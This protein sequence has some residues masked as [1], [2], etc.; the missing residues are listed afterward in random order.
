MRRLLSGRL[1][2]SGGSVGQWQILGQSLRLDVGQRTKLQMPPAFPRAL[3]MAERV[4]NLCAMPEL[5]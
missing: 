4:R 3:K 5:D 1:E 2:L